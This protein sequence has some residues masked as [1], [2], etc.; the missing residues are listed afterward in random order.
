MW[1][2]EEGKRGDGHTSPLLSLE[3]EVRLGEVRCGDGHTAPLLLLEGE[4][5]W[6]GV[7]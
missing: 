7:R 2:G 1:C 6:G 5:R 4:V 3:G